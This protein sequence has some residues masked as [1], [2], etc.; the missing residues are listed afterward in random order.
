MVF[1]HSINIE[2]NAICIVSICMI[3]LYPELHIYSR[4]IYI[5]IVCFCILFYMDR[6]LLVIWSDVYGLFVSTQ[7]IN[8]ACTWML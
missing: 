5:Y 4:S 6:R 7:L 8:L 3:W 2:Q 1:F